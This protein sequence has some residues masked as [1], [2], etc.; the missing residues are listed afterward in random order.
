MIAVACG[1]V[2][3]TTSIEL[4]EGTYSTLYATGQT[5]SLNDAQASYRVGSNY[6][7]IILRSSNIV[8]TTFNSE[9]LGEQRVQVVYSNAQ[10]LTT[11]SLMVTVEESA[12][13]KF[14]LDNVPTLHSEKIRSGH[15]LSHTLYLDRLTE[16]DQW[17]QL[18]DVD[19]SQH[20]G[21]L[22][23][24]NG[25]REK[26][27]LSANM[28]T[29][30]VNLKKLKNA[31][32]Q[33]LRVVHRG[34]AAK[35]SIHLLERQ[36]TVEVNINNRED[37]ITNGATLQSVIKQIGPEIVSVILPGAHYQLT[38]LISQN[39]QPYLELSRNNFSLHGASLDDRPVLRSAKDVEHRPLPHTLLVSGDSVTLRGIEVMN[40]YEDQL[41]SIAVSGDDFYLADS[42]VSGTDHLLNGVNGTSLAIG[43]DQSANEKIGTYRLFNNRFIDGTVVLTHG[44]GNKAS[45]TIQ[46]LIEANQFVRSQLQVIGN[47]PNRNIINDIDSTRLPIVENNY[48]LEPS[49]T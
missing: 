38:P 26:V 16:V 20:F 15:Y 31:S 19:P 37:A 46:P 7:I 22:T 28:I 21:T 9:S 14:E 41:V 5:F 18:F 4:I 39:S 17:H 48:F 10:L 47:D 29:A 12:P 3:S 1:S 23:Y 43:F 45:S 35:F 42:L 6:S 27:G 34:L 40:P 25:A 33:I 30:S 32:E 13:A 36:T 11:F 44:A 49:E 8:S 2:D 24:V